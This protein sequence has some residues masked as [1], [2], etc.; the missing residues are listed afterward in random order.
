MFLA[1]FA[2]TLVMSF[3]ILRKEEEMK[4]F[5]SKERKHRFA[6]IVFLIL[7]IWLFFHFITNDYAFGEG[8]SNIENE[9]L[10]K[11]QVNF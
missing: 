2:E 9:I 10:A 1:G 7:A 5:S 11:V 3:G 6:E 4:I 8:T